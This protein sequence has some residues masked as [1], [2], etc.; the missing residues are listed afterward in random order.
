MTK[1]EQIRSELAKLAKKYGPDATIIAKVVS[2]NEDEFTCVVDEDGI[3]INDV[4]LR[5]VINTNES[6]TIIPKVNSYVAITRLEDDEEWMVIA[7]DEIEK[8]RIVNGTMLFEMHNGKFLIE[9]GAQNLG[10]CLDDLIIEIQA[11]YAPKNSAGITAI[12]T[13]L[14]TLLSGS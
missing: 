13:R 4:R 3:E 14:K 11:I 10:K 2:V 7:V 5:P 1:E 6:V 12:Q 9:S 8:Y